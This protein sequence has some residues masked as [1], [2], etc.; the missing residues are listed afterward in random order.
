L[1][2]VFQRMVAKK[3]E[4]RFA[5]MSEVVAALKALALVPEP[6]PKQSAPPAAAPNIAPTPTVDIARGGQETGTSQSGNQTLDLGPPRTPDIAGMSLLLVEPS[7]S[8]AFIIRG[9]LQQLGYKDITAVAEGQKALELA[10]TTPPRV[11]ISAMHLPDMTGVQLAQKLRAEASLTSTG[12]VLITSQTDAQEANL[13]SQAGNLIRLPKPFD[14]EHLTQAL[15]VAVGGSS[16]KLVPAWDRLRVL[17]VDDSAAARVHIRGV[18]AG[19]GMRTIMEAADGA[20]ALAMLEGETFD[21]VVTDYS[22]PRLDGR[23]LIEYIRHRGSHPSVPIIMV[24]T[25]T[26]PGK[27]AA[28]R[29][30]GVTAICDKSFRPDEVRCVLERLG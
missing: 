27:L 6:R 4:D 19:L 24:T 17:L 3:P 18:L 21:R 7:R 8:Q 14:R 5:S 2:Q 25:E 16:Q 11:V 29:Q 26:D 23:G 28:V 30:L 12:F 15:A 13:Q 9:Y 22:M 10:R 20:E 1:D